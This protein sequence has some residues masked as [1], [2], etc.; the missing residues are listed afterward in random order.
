MSAVRSRRADY[1]RIKVAV[2]GNN[3]HV[4]RRHRPY[5]TRNVLKGTLN[6]IQKIVLL[7]IQK[8]FVQKKCASYFDKISF[9]IINHFIVKQP[10]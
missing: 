7:T 4:T 5:M 6:P 10:Y 9:Y 3:T 2:S 8:I 1:S